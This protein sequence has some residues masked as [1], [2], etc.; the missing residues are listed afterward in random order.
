MLSYVF[1]GLTSEGLF[2]PTMAHAGLLKDYAVY[3]TCKGGVLDENSE[4]FFF[5]YFSI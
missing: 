2:S 5:S 3:R 1:A 4:L